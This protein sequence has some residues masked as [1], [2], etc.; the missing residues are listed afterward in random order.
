MSIRR[1]VPNIASER[2]EESRA[3]YT[4]FLGFDVAMDMGWIVT[5]VSPTNETAQISLGSGEMPG[6]PHLTIEVDDVDEVHARARE[7]GLP[8]VYALTDES[9]GVRR[10][11]VEDPNGVVL[12]VMSHR[13]G[14]AA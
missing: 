11:F 10:F 3:F 12:N 13:G 9:W 8:I 14:E 6:G 7:Q 5:L 1:V 4:H 2:P